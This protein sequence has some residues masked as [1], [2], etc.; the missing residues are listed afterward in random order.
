MDKRLYELPKE[1]LDRL[2]QL[3][4]QQF[5]AICRTFLDDK[6]TTF[7]INFIKINIP[8]LMQAFSQAQVR[9]KRVPWL[10]YA[11]ILEF[12]KQREFE[13]TSI[14]LNGQI[15]VQ[16]I[17]SMLPVAVLDPQ[18]GEVILDLCAAPGGKTTQ[19]VSVTKGQ[20][21][22]VA[23]EFVKPRWCKLE[24]NIKL[25]G[26]EAYIDL[27]LGDGVMVG[28]ENAG[29]FDRVL[30][31]APCSSESGFLANHPRSYGYWS[32]KTVKECQSK[33]KQL[34]GAGVHA[35]K[36]NG[37][38]VYSTCT[39]SP[40]ENEEVVSWALEKFKQQIVLEPIQ[41]P[42]PGA[43]PGLAAWQGKKLGTDLSFT[44]RILPNEFLEAFYIA[45][46]RKIM[47]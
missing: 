32:L 3:Y 13:K 41:F 31:D 44:K 10:D 30:V 36:K 1:F 37:I 9:V 26:H 33:Q 22:V 21:K 18:P 17:S 42:L 19:I 8:G 15:Y 6:Q 29:R 5:H 2:Q 12:P 27:I 14:Y 35:L 16:N 11:W 20:A 46:F 25:Q 40:E 23:V 47:E 7:R 24:A 34:L 39:F 28:K 45:R 4:P 43:R 38:L